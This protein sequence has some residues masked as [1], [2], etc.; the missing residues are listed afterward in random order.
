MKR[1]KLSVLL[2][3]LVFLTIITLT[4]F[5]YLKSN[6]EEALNT[7][8]SDSPDTVV[9][10]ITQGESLDTIVPNLISKGLL[11]EEHHNYFIYYLKSNKIVPEIQA[12]TFDIPKNLTLIELAQTLKQANGGSVWVTITEG[13]RITEIAKIISQEFS[14]ITEQS[15]IDTAND[16]TYI[17]SLGL[18]VEEISSLEGFLFPDRYLFPPN[19]GSQEIISI[20]VENFNSRVNHDYTYE[21]IVLASLIER[22]AVNSE[23]RRIISGIL[24]KRLREQWLLQVDA[25]LL[26][27]HENWEHVITVADK[28]RDHVYNTYKFHGLPPQPICNPG[29]DS[30]KSVLEP[31]ETPYYYYIHDNDRN[32]H[33]SR[34][35]E[36]HER[37]VQK[38]LR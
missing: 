33:Y 10:E 20:M 23:D 34:T 31:K 9:F 32:P 30:I 25:T 19:A 18:D 14:E 16:E 21:D 38:Y 26:Y 17:N 24:Q 7:P 27:Y 4:I 12:G 36:E 28:E 3:M 29:L 13:M 8:N 35:L 37:K 15:F 2:A 1:K 11:R 22:E 5:L 6:Y